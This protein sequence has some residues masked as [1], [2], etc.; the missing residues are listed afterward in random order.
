MTE[1]ITA[2]SGLTIPGAIGLCAICAL[3]GFVSYLIWR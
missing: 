2:L 3:I 1:I